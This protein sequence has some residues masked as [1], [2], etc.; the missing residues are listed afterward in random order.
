MDK[1][2]EL[3]EKLK[4]LQRPVA[5]LFYAE[6]I[7]VE[8]ETCTVEVAGLQVS[9]VKLKAT[10]AEGSNYLYHVPEVGK[11]I[12]V[13]SLSGD[14]R[15]LVMLRADEVK[16]V[17]FKYGTLEITADGEDE[18][19]SIKNGDT[20]LK[21]LFDNLKSLISSLTVATSTGPSG[22]PLPPTQSALTTFQSNVSKLFK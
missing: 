16:Q 11:M 7:S 19:V 17:V 5:V 9:D 22:T 20:S 4:A 21:G 2:A 6:V 1:Y 8:G 14:L 13:G 12:L 3:A 18:K 10:G 15:E